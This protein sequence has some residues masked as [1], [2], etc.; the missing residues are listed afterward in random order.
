VEDRI[1]YVTVTNAG[2]TKISG[3]K[4]IGKIKSGVFQQVVSS[5]PERDD[6]EVGKVGG[7]VKM[8]VP[9]L[10]KGESA[11]MTMLVR[12][13]PSGGSPIFNVRSNDVRGVLEY[14]SSI[15]NR[16]TKDLFTTLAA[17]L[18]GLG[19]VLGALSSR[20]ILRRNFKTPDRA[21]IIWFVVQSLRLDRMLPLLP[22]NWPEMRYSAVA[23]LLERCFEEGDGLERKLAIAGLKSLFLAPMIVPTSRKV[24]IED[25]KRLDPSFDESE[26]MALKA[27]RTKSRT[28]QGYRENVRAL[29][30]HARGGA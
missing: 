7:S 2:D 16:Q 12:T 11:A 4:A 14:P 18:A 28:Q 20:I 23:D 3:I 1:Y 25:L 30:S 15:A 9:T 27:L 22:N 13:P 8:T 19:A 5:S 10:L 29:I 6:L 26:E 24:I 17:L 21:E